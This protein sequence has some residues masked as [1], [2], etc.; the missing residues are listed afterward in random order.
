[1]DA[2][3]DF[4]A[5][6]ISLRNEGRSIDDLADDIIDPASTSFAGP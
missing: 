2:V 3:H 4:G 1:M 6:I 5:L